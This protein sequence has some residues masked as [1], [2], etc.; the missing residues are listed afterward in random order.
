MNT[1]GFKGVYSAT[2]TPYDKNGDVNLD[3]QEKIIDF[4]LRNG[5]KGLYLC[6]ST[7]EGPLLNEKERILVAQNAVKYCEGK[8]KTIVHVGCVST[9]AAIILSE[10]A[11]EHGADAVSSIYPYYYNFPEEALFRYYRELSD[12]VDIPMI[13]YIY[14]Q[15]SGRSISKEFI[16]RLFKLKNVIGAKY[17][18]SDYSAVSGIFEKAEREKILFSGADEL[19]MNGLCFGAKGAIGAFQNVI[20]GA[21][22]RLYEAFSAGNM[23]KMRS[24]QRRINN[25]IYFVISKGDMSYYKASIRYIG[26]DCGSARKP[27]KQL[28]EDEYAAF[29]EELKKFDDLF[30]MSV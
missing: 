24:L 11:K 8:G 3:M 26:F 4:Q 25:F 30:E 20:P 21:F 1:S 14:P 28:T 7:G 12:A 19:M 6:G 18:G 22:V 2:F 23:D 29:A 16:L 5:L 17:T 13:I 15:L 9:D 10:K 27:F